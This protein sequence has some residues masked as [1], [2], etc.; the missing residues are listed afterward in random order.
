MSIRQ[1]LMTGAVFLALSAG[2][3]CAS[4][5]EKEEET[6]PTTGERMDAVRAGIGDAAVTPLRDVGLLRPEIPDILETIRYPYDTSRLASGCQAVAYEIGQL[7][8]VLGE[9]NFQPGP[10]RDT[11]DRAADAAQD[12][13]IGAVRGAADVI[14]FRGWVRQ[15]SGATRAERDAIAAF[16]IGQIRRSFLRGYGASL[17]CRGVLPQPPPEEQQSRR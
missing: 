4:R 14:P 15:L 12:A 6:G 2:A 16:E 9:E 17:G 13:A 11:G 10:R 7:D 3:G 5:G 8:A 1:V